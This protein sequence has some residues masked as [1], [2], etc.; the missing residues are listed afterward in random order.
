MSISQPA[1][2][3]LLSSP[4]HSLM[5]RQIA[6]D[7]LAPVQSLTVDSTGKISFSVGVG[8]NNLSSDGTL[9]G[10]SDSTIPTEKAIKNYIDGHFI[11]GVTWDESADTYVR[12]GSIAGQ[13]LGVKLADGLL[14]I[15][16]RMRRCVINDAGVVQYYLS[17][18]NSAYKEDGVTASVLTGADGQVMVEIPKFYYK[19]SYSG[20][21]HTYEISLYPIAG[22][23]VHPAF[24]LDAVAKDHLY[25]GAYEGVLYDNSLSAYVGGVYQPAVSCVF[26][27]ADKSLTIATLS[28]WAS[29]LTVGQKLVI[30]GTASNNATITVASIVS[31]TKI[32][33]DEALTDETAAATVIQVQTDVTATTGDKLSSVSGFAPITGCV[34]NG[35][36]AHFRTYSANRGAGWSQM[37]IDVLSA[38]QLLYLVEYASFYSQSVI[39][40]GISNVTNWPAYSNYNSLA[41]SGNSNTIGNASGNTAGST[42]CATESTKYMSYRGIENWYGHIWKWVDGFN[43]NDNIPYLC[44]NIANFAD[45]T[46]TNYTRPVDV[47]AADIT[48]INANGYQNLLAKI[49]R[50]FFPVSIAAPADASHKITDYYYQSTGWRVAVSGDSADHGAAGGGFCLACT[51]AASFLSR[52][53]SGR[54]VFRS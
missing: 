22:F 43:I 24:L 14:P 15:Q 20:T 12:T 34:A 1:L 36:R 50:G 35:T 33:I 37:F 4:D 26:A 21:S 17:A 25:V 52:F 39:G 16:S 38:I 3:D 2:T 31:G 23:T 11:Q 6:T 19:Y 7:P 27:S 47:L 42:S 30:T 32:T 53:I 9:V 48:M 45:A 40:A 44:N 51:Y 46:V 49:G 10:N 41:K 18:I 54:L 13:T 8:V 28:G 5:H 29:V